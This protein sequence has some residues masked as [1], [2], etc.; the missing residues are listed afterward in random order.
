MYKYLVARDGWH[1]GWRRSWGHVLGE[2][3]LEGED[4]CPSAQ[5]VDK[6]DL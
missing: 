3:I 2:P 6:K 5:E 4:E 1:F